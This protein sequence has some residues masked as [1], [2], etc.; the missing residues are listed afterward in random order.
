MRLPRQVLPRARAAD[1]GTLL[2]REGYQVFL[3]QSSVPDD[4]GP[5]DSPPAST[6]SLPP[7]PSPRAAGPALYAFKGLA[8]RLGPIGV[9][10]AL[11]AVLVGSAD[12]A[13]AGWV[14]SAMCPQGQE[15]RLG[16]AIAPSGPLALVPA[17]ADARLRVNRFFIDYSPDGAAF[18]LSLT[19]LSPLFP[20]SLC[21]AMP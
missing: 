9:H 6:S 11:L 21:T 7:A 15:F 3:A 5:A 12:S 19:D 16:D 18:P 17:V 1:L 2:T 8:G 10:A 14:G 4:D 13:L 20:V